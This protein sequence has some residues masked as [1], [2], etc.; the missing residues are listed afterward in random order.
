MPHV[1]LIRSKL[2]S[3]NS[4]FQKV[5]TKR[6]FIFYQILIIRQ[7]PLN[8]TLIINKYSLTPTN[9]TFNSYYIN[10]YFLHL[11]KDKNYQRKLKRLL[12]IILKLNSPY[13]RGLYK[14][15]LLYIYDN[16]VLSLVNVRFSTHSLTFDIGD[17][18]DNIC[19]NRLKS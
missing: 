11:L 5:I 9:I 4:K 17:E 15:T 18:L 13:K 8:F 7:E 16:L 10:H 1:I 6:N 3:Y 19:H 14:E 12:N 2:D